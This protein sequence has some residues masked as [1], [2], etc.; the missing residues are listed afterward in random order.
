M[1]SVQNHRATIELFQNRLLQE[2]D[3]LKQKLGMGYE[4]E[5]KWLPGAKKELCGEVN[6]TCIY[7]YDE[8]EESALSTLKHEF[9]DYIISRTIE[10]Y[11]QIANKLIQ[12]TNEEAYR[13]KE[14]L[15]NALAKLI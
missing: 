2:L 5:L 1:K 11:E 7:I 6:G 10:P 14:R 13:R 12:L 15:T 8:E 9:L 4:L 3:R